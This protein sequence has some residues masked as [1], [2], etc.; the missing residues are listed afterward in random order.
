M[1]QTIACFFSLIRSGL[2]NTKIDEN[3]FSAQTDWKMIL[4]TSEQQTV[5]G[6][7]FDGICQLPKSQQPPQELMQK[8]IHRVLWIEQSH[9]LLNKQILEII[10]RLQ[11][12]S[13]QPILLKG[14]G[15][16]KNYPNA[17]RRQ[18]GDIDL[19]VGEQ[20]CSKATDILLSMDATRDNKT[21]RE[22]P[23]HES[24]YLNNV[25][26]EL[27]FLVEKLRNPIYNKRF[28]TWVNTSF[29]KDNLTYFSI[30]NTR[31]A[32]PSI[33]FYTLYIFNHAYHHLI[34]GGIG[35]RQL[36][37]W[38]IFLHTH[39]TS[40]NKKD[41]FFHLKRIGILK[42]WQVFG[43]ILVNELGLPKDD[44]PFYSEKYKKQAKKILDI[45][46]E[47]GNFGMYGS[48]TKKRSTNYLQ[49]KLHSLYYK[50]KYLLTLL[51][52][53]PTDTAIFYITYWKDGLKSILKGV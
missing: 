28:Q 10:P 5:M 19:F 41:L 34:A 25:S 23:K 53:F 1:N 50:Q 27:H 2:W 20:Y 17:R 26:I 13:I 40:I 42:P 37:D 4:T 31:I 7:L 38:A 44:F 45:I 39:K 3:L 16:A 43:H 52:I 14:Q 11:A 21:M 33:N 47:V 12:D 36:C 9:D 30:N 35:L 6:I 22:S 29:D 8:L 49:K 51:P 46:I 15:L 24:F 18:C 32:L 48:A